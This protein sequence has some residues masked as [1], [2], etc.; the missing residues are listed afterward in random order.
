M[1]DRMKRSLS[2]FL[3]L[4]LMLAVPVSAAADGRG[5]YY[6]PALTF[7]AE[8]APKD[9]MLRM[10]LPRDGET[11]PVFLFRED[12]LWESYFRLYR[13]TEQE[14]RTWY[15]NRVDFQDAV[16]VAM[17]EDGEVR[18]PIPEEDLIKLTMNDFFMLDCS[19]YSLSYGLPTGRTVML[20]LLRFAITLGASLAVFSF[21]HYYWKRS[22]IAVILTNMICQGTLSLFVSN[23]INYNPKMIAVHFM[24]LLAVLIVQ[25]PIFWWTLDENGAQTSVGYTVVSNL[26]TGALN[27]FFLIHFPL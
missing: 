24:A 12:R 9:L 20:F 26:V 21:F 23:W 15:G 5:V 25:I 6:R 4:L 7:I 10:D 27:S 14:I 18:I 17:T 1:T 19:D 3:V 2:F 11:V 16:L 8:N 22:W 13:Q